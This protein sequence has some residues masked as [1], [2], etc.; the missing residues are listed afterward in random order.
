MTTDPRPLVGEPLA[1]DLLNTWWDTTGQLEDLLTDV[2]GL[3]IWLDSAGLP[4]PADEATLDATRDARAALAAARAPEPD[5]GPLNDVLARGRLKLSVAGTQ[6]RESPEV[7]DTAWLP[8][9]LAARNYLELLKQE[10]ARI[11]RCANPQCVL[12]FFDISKN[13]KRAWCSMTLCGNRAK[14]ARHY[15]RNR[16]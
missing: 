8:G 7:P 16:G 14:A 11:R 12:H 3:K 4:V 9:W 15:S 10:P 2:A 13:G 5:L 1:L 6:P